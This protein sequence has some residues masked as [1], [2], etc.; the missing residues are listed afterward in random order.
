MQE[1]IALPARTV[2]HARQRSLRFNEH[3]PGF[4]AFQRVRQRLQA[5]ASG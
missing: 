1:L 2:R 3:S 5:C 4:A